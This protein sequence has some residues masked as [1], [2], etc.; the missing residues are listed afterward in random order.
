[1][2][3]LKLIFV[4]FLII[5]CSST[6]TEKNEGFI[7]TGTTKDIADGTYIELFDVSSEQVFDSTFVEN[8]KFEFKG[9]LE[10]SPARMVLQT[11]ENWQYKFLWLENKP[12]TIDASDSDLMN[13]KVTGSEIQ[14]LSD[15]HFDR[16]KNIE[17]YDEMLQ[18]EMKFIEEYPNSIISASNLSAYSTAFGKTKVEELY[19][20]LSTE[21]QESIFGKQIQKYLELNKSPQVGDGYVDFEME[22]DVGA[23]VRLSENLGKFTL[24]EFWASN[25]GPC[26]AENPNLV[27]TYNEFKESGFEIFAVSLDSN[28]DNWKKAIAE[29][30][31][32]W[33]Q[34]S[35]LE[36]RFNKASLI[37]GINGIPDN[38]LLD[39]AGK[40]VGRN[41]RGENLDAELGK[42]LSLN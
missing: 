42:L 18:M 19:H 35:D 3:V 22:N 33:T 34:V 9:R 23:K 10:N 26:R 32:P 11:R 28:E 21:N 5:G 17:D 7:L 40:I 6:E 16:M 1:M 4:L 14:V 41:L 29:D 30:K 37:Y 38:F 36:G 8:N 15:L 39:S 25:C 24:L 27:N 20:K 12:M 2:K 13:S 31:L